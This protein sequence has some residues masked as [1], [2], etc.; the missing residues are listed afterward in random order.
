MS[1]SSKIYSRSCRLIET[2]LCA[3]WPS[4]KNLRYFCSSLPVLSCPVPRLPFPLISA[5]RINIFSSGIQWAWKS[6]VSTDLFST[7]RLHSRHLRLSN[8]RC[9][10]CK[11]CCIYFLIHF[12]AS[13]AFTD[14]WAFTD[15]GAFTDQFTTNNR[16]SAENQR[17]GLFL[18]HFVRLHVGRPLSSFGFI[19]L[20]QWQH[21]STTKRTSIRGEVT[22]DSSTG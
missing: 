13:E 11:T 6:C 18:C 20:L 2:L 10:R 12:S 21:S 17:Q 8:V 15:H 9:S 4:D 19:R 14:P 7:C 1:V 3:W 22:R 5:I 16:I